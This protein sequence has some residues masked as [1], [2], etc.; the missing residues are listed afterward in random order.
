LDAGTVDLLGGTISIG[1]A[2][3][4]LKDMNKKEIYSG[5][6]NKFNYAIWDF[7]NRTADVSQYLKARFRS[8]SLKVTEKRFSGFIKTQ[9]EGI[10]KK[11]SSNRINEEYFVFEDLFGKIVQKCNY[12]D[13][14]RR[15]MEKPVRREDLSISP[16]LAKIMINLSEVKENGIL[17]DGFCGIG[18][19]LIE[20]LNMG[21][22]AIGIDKNGEAI[23]GARKNLEWMKFPNGTYRLMNNDSTKTVVGSVDVL[24]SEPDFGKTFKEVPKKGEADNLVRKFENLMIDVLNNMKKSVNGK[25][26]FTSPFI[27]IGRD[28]MG[29][30]FSRICSKTGLK[31]EEG[32]PIKE[33]REGQIVGREIVV[34][35]K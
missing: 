28:R 9:D 2:M 26:V 31:L 3:C 15:D 29:C 5:S 20:A 13:I 27:N 11:L 34:L 16:R 25:F 32:F 17:L 7:S 35:K 21:V 4:H 23:N 14:E 30:D 1:I 10:V 22:K 19:I 33:F 12:K 6:D 24:V 18:S 8:E